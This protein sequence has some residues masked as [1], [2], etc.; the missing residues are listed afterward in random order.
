MKTL[1]AA[2]AS[3]AALALAAC[4]G[5][6]KPTLTRLDCPKT[7]HGLTRVSAAADGKSCAYVSRDGAEI[8]LTL[9]P[10]RGSVEAT[11][12]AIEKDLRASLENATP[13]APT[14][15]ARSDVA[16]PAAASTAR[17]SA[18][19]EA[20]AQADAGLTEERAEKDGEWKTAEGDGDHARVDLPG[21]HID[22]RDDSASVRVGPI[23]IDADDEGAEIRMQ[24]D[25]RLRGESLSPQKRGVRA[26]L[27]LT[28]D[29]LPAGYAFAGY[30]AGG[31]KAGPLAVA[32][33]KAK[34]K[35][36]HHEEL[37]AAVK[38]LVRRNGG[39]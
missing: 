33:V 37:Y 35:A 4:D 12:K 26:T 30:E 24:R 36:R 19:V 38:A 29:E 34:G 25:V 20:T 7:E 18:A 9:A 13:S 15:A 39:V 23:H 10:V 6:P 1:L 22:A 28:G 32:V 8:T 17:E 21:V 27:V 16:P 14:E 31:P 5:T 2:A 11:L 3:T